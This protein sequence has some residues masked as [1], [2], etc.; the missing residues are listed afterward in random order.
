MWI[1]WRILLKILFPCGPQWAKVWLRHWAFNF[2]FLPP[3]CWKFWPGTRDAPH[4]VWQYFAVTNH[5]FINVQKTIG[6]MM[7]E[8]E[9]CLEGKISQAQRLGAPWPTLMTRNLVWS[10]H[11]SAGTS[12]D[13]SSQCEL[14]LDDWYRAGCAETGPRAVLPQSESLFHS[15]LFLNPRSEPVEA[16]KAIFLEES[17]SAKCGVHIFAYVAYKFHPYISCT[18]LHI[19]CI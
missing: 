14:K 13:F 11:R 4:Y 17:P 7:R 2:F 12:G 19:L 6:E 10:K 15:E 1:D 8:K 9:P 18:F 3:E 16:K 5:A